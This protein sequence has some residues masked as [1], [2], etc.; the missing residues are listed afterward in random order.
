MAGLAGGFLLARCTREGSAQ[1]VG[2]PV[3][4]VID[5]CCDLPDLVMD[6][7][8][9]LLGL[10]PSETRAWRGAGLIAENPAQGARLHAEVIAPRGRRRASYGCGRL[11]VGAAGTGADSGAGVISGAAAA[12]ALAGCG[13]VLIASISVPPVSL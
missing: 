3:A 5:G 10:E 11:G 1:V 2:V 8:L 13:F 9:G 4:R 12:G 7:P 6:E